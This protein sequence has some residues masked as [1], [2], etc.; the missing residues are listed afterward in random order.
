MREV[1][2]FVRS[3]RDAVTTISLSVSSLLAS[4]GAVAAPAVVCAIAGAATIDNASADS[5]A[6]AQR[7]DNFIKP[8][9]KS[10]DR[11]P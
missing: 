2:S 9:R 10:D 7:P 8:S 11:I 1:S 4:A 3:P 5:E 6:H